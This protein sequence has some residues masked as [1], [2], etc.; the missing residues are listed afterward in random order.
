MLKPR[1]VDLV[2]LPEMIFTG[3]ASFLHTNIQNIELDTVCICTGYVFPNAAS[4]SPFLETPQIGPTSSF[5]AELASRLRCYVAAGFPECLEQAERPDTSD[6]A[7]ADGVH[8]LGANSAVIYGP[9]GYINAYRKTNLYET[10][11]TW[12]K[13]GTGFLTLTL[14]PPLNKVTLGICMDLNVQPPAVWTLDD[15]PYELAQHALDTQSNILVILNAWLASDQDPDSG[16][17]ADDADWKTLNYW[18]ARLQPLWRERQGPK[19]AGHTTAVVVCNRTGVENGITFAGSSSLFVMQEG[20][21]KPG[22]VDAM[23]RR[24]EGF[25]LWVL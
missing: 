9:D 2:C 18:A 5:C 8:Q 20:S 22:L 4:I 12:A 19:S 14:P 10:D 21:G 15:G 11:M 25:R 24:E 3:A 1:S 23:G 7:V 6:D 13:P 16:S 17:D